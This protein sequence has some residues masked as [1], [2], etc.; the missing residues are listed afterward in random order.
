MPPDQQAHVH[1]CVLSRVCVS[2]YVP[3][4]SLCMHSHIAKCMSTCVHT[5]VFTRS[6]VLARVFLC[7]RLRECV[8]ALAR[9]SVCVPT[10]AC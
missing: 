9:V 10:C 5:C 3:C 8:C 6:S 2:V 1:I 4:V 7:P